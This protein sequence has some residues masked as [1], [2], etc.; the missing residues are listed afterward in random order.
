MQTWAITATV[1]AP[2]WQVNKFIRHYLAL[3]ASEVFIFFDD[4]SMVCEIDLDNVYTAICDDNYWKGKR[5]DGLE[6]R[7]RTNATRAKNKCASDWIM[8]CDIDELCWSDV[9]VS[10]VLSSQAASIGGLMVASREAL[11]SHP[12]AD[13]G[14]FKTCFFKVFGDETNPRAYESIARDMF[15]TLWK[16]SKCGFWGHVQ[17]KSFIRKVANA[18]RMPLHH[19]A[20]DIPG[21]EMR[22]KTSDIVL[23]HYDSASFQLWRD[24]HIR[25]IKK[26]VMVSN[27][28]KF[29]RAQQAA[30]INAYEE[31]DEKGLWRVYLEMTCPAALQIVKGIEAGF[32]QVIPPEPHLHT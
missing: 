28:G 14:I 23:R 5:P 12:P 15:P 32:I 25:R 24:K 10:E 26:D 18:G 20:N 7:Q 9:G 29:R 21:Y 13:E 4:P 30:I 6:D 1:R 3:G 22:A 8:H 2:D 16:A 31:G 19:K 27:A 17:G 11:Y